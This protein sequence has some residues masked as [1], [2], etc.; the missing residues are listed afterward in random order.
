MSVTALFQAKLS[1]FLVWTFLGMI[2]NS[3]IPCSYHND[4]QLI[5]EQLLG[6]VRIKEV[7]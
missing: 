6:S 4:P 7:A 5:V 3:Y 2:G 1:S